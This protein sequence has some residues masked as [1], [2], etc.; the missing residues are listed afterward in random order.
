GAYV[1]SHSGNRYTIGARGF[2]LADSAAIVGRKP[3]AGP[4]GRRRWRGCGLS[5]SPESIA[6]LARTLSARRGCAVG[7]SCDGIHAGSFCANQ[8]AVWNAPSAH[9]EEG[10]STL[11][12]GGP[13]SGRG[14]EFASEEGADYR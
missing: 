3:A 6:A 11:L 2:E 9:R 4:R 8:R 14:R 13:R 5:R 10:R 1:A 7:R 12:D